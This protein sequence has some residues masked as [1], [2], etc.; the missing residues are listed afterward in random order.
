MGWWGWGGVDVKES[1]LHFC[2]LTLCGRWIAHVSTL[3][4]RLAVVPTSNLEQS[5]L[6]TRS[7]TD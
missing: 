7:I 4:S 6:V 1:L 3:R 5:V 2:G